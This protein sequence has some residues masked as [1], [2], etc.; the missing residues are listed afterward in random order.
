MILIIYTTEHVIITKHRTTECL[1]KG[2]VHPKMKILSSFTYRQVVPN[3][4]ELGGGLLTVWLL[5]YLLW[6]STEE[7]NSY[8]FGTTL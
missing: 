5:T 3:M 7:R 2:I 8:R 4:Y 1:F 6:G